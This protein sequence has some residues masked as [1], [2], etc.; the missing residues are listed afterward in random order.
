LISPH[1]TPIKILCLCAVFLA[2]AS[3]SSSQPSTVFDL[4]APRDFGY[5]SSLSGQVV[6]AEPSA[7]QIYD[8]E[9]IIVREAQ[10]TLS[11]VPG[12]QWSERLPRLVQT[13]LIQA[14]QNASKLR[15]IG[16]PG[17]RIVADYQINLEIRAFEVDAAQGQ[18]FVEIAARLVN[19]RTGQVVKAIIARAAEPVSAI[20]GPAS[21]Q[22]LDAALSR[23]LVDIIRSF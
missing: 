20:D 13:R 7:L 16:R 19:D 23:T 21:A 14:Y 2:L 15:N 17:E 10:G 1:F 11:Q 9:R 8:S 18:A 12:V 4:T 5:K 3:C 22:A 6:V